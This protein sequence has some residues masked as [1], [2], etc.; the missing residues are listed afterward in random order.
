MIGRILLV[1]ATTIVTVLSA[2][3]IAQAVEYPWCAYYGG[4]EFSAT[5]CGFSTFAQCRATVSGIGGSCQPNPAY[6][7]R[8]TEGRSRR[9]I[10]R[11]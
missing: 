3:N 7:G 11:Y 10:E 2:N 5:N 1:G 6:R 4:R 9:Q 8:T